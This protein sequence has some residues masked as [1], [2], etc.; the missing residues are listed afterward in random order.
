MCEP[1]E[2]F[3]EQLHLYHCMH[4]PEKVEDNPTYQKWLYKREVEM[5]SACGQAPEAEKIRFEDEYERAQ[6]A[7]AEEFTL[8]CRKCRFV[9]VANRLYLRAC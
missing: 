8:K 7:A 3:M 1:N 4:T 2:G 5:S 6:D 9:N